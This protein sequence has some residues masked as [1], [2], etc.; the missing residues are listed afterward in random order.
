MKKIITLLV[1]TC[2]LQTHA[3]IDSTNVPTTQTPS[4]ASTSPEEQY[5]KYLPNFSPNSP[6]VAAVKKYGD[7]PINY[8]TGVTDISIP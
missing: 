5:K 7:Y 6:N 8:A 4:S 2:I 3:Q 1:F